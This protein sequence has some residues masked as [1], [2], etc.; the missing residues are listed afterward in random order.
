[1]PTR[2]LLL[3]VVLAALLALVL[4]PPPA[5]AR[6]YDEARVPKQTGFPYLEGASSKVTVRARP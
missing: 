6:T 2:L 5:G 3:L 1:M 4:W